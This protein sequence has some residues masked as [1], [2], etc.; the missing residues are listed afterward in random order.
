MSLAG[1]RAEE[2]YIALYHSN[3][4]I[5][6]VAQLWTST[7]YHVSANCLRIMLCHDAY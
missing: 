6:Y 4:R 5:E 3:D 7:I 1:E 2:V